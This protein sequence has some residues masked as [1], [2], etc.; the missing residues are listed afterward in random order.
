MDPLYDMDLSTTKI[1]KSID[2]YGAEEHVNTTQ[3]LHDAAPAIT[4]VPEYPGTHT[5]RHTPSQAIQA[6]IAGDAAPAVPEEC[7][8]D[9][10]QGPPVAPSAA[11]VMD[12][13]TAAKVRVLKPYTEILSQ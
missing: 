9:D 8:G 1:V 10:D 5:H 7:N 3:L 4:Q 6:A 13:C 12:Q 11:K 2:E